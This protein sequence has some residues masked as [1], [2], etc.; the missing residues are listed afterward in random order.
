MAQSSWPDPATDREITDVQYEQLAARFS[1]DGVYGTPADAAV[2][3]AGT[4]LSVRLRADVYASVRGHGWTSG[5]T[6]D[7]LTIA[8][9]TSGETRTDRIVLRLS[10]TTWKVRAVVLQG[11]PGD[12]PPTLTT[13]EGFNSF[14][15]LL[16]NVTILNGAG[17]VTVTRGERY[18]GSRIRPTTSTSLTDPNPQ[19]ADVK[20]ETDTKRLLLYDGSADRTIYS[21]SGPIVINSPLLA[22]S[23]ETDSVIEERNGSVHLRLGSFVRRAGALSGG[24]VSRL[25]V[26]IPAAYRHPTRDRYVIAYVTGLQIARLTIYS[27]VTDKAGQVWITQHPTISTG[28][29][30]LTSGSSWVV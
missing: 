8:P 30:V 21:D 18:V 10:R 26:L 27:A 16:A 25:P 13:G 1:D 7:T 15:V 24:T 5:S 29:A 9:N 22:W 3:T 12:G 14:E 19:L 2:V 17:S 28:D 23:T 4:G 6:G 11:T 20:W